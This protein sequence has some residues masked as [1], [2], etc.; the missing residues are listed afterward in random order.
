MLT[1]VGSWL[2]ADAQSL[3]HVGRAPTLTHIG[4]APMRTH[5]GRAPTL[6]H[7]GRDSTL[8]NSHHICRNHSCCD[9]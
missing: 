2:C 5:V 9:L 6:T 4:C 1:H 8:T 7:I 3:T